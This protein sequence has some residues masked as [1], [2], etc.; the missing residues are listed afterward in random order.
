MK[1]PILTAAA[2]LLLGT[3]AS[4]FARQEKGQDDHPQG[5]KPAKQ[6]SK[7][8]ESRPQAKPAERQ[9]TQ[10]AK[11]E[12]QA[13]A[14]P[15]Q[16]AKTVPQQQPQAK[17]VERQQT[18]SVKTAQQQH[19]QQA[20]TPEQQ[21][22]KTASRTEQGN[23]GT[24]PARTQQSRTEST[25]NGSSEHGRISNAHYTTSFGSGHSFHV[26][27]GDYAHRR[28]QY[29]GYSFGF[30]DA[31]PIGWGYS[32]DVYVVYADGGYYMYDAFHPGLRI[33]LSIL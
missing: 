32:D 21:P 15:A 18:Q 9:Q 28:F 19:T 31:W 14:K 3:T 16:Q 26:N 8:A 25:N 5:A 23:A 33:S 24:S 13:Q 17:P 22:A 4:M 10:A 30:I 12:P 20:A 1:L 11:P 6:E 2:F 27:Q 29:G 7:P